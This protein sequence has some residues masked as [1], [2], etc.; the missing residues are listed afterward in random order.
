MQDF[1]PE[2]TRKEQGLALTPKIALSLSYQREILAI[3]GMREKTVNNDNGVWVIV[4]RVPP[5]DSI[6]S[7]PS[8]QLSV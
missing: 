5:K 3:A 2:R 7:P 6:G 1:N 8:G 4:E